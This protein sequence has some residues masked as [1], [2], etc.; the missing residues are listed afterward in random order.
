[1]LQNYYENVV[2]KFR[3]PKGIKKILAKIEE[4]KTEANPECTE[5]IK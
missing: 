2:D 1:V 4:K 5:V 3:D